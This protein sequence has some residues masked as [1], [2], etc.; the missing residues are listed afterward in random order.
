[1]EALAAVAAREALAAGGVP[2]Q[3][4][5]LPAG[6]WASWTTAAAAVTVPVEVSWIMPVHNGA[7]FLG[8]AL[9]S[10][11]AQTM[12]PAKV[13][14]ELSLVDD[15][16]TDATWSVVEGHVPRLLERGWV[17]TLGRNLS[18]TARGCGWG[19]NAAIKQARGRWVCFADADDVSHPDRLQV[20]LAAALRAE[21]HFG[22]D[23]DRT[24]VGANFVRTPPGSTVRYTA[25]LNRLTAAELHLHRF[26]EVTLIKPTWLLRHSRWASL[27]GLHEGG[28]GT[29]EDMLFFY[30]HLEHGGRLLKA[31]TEETGPLSFL[32]TGADAETSATA[33]P[34]LAALAERVP[35][36]PPWPPE[37][38]LVG[39]AHLH[40]DDN[41]EEDEARRADSPEERAVAREHGSRAG[42]ETAAVTTTRPSPRA[43]AT[44]AL[45][46]AVGGPPPLLTYRYHRASMTH[47]VHRDT[48]LVVRLRALERQVLGR[49]AHF[50]IWNAGRQ[51][52]RLYALL[53]PATQRKVTA[54][55][56]VAERK[57]AHGQYHRPGMTRAVPIVHFRAAVPPLL[58]CVK[59]D[60]TGGDFEA[61]LA[62]LGLRPGVDYVY[63]C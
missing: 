62:S 46:V 34:S 44:G 33:V 4:P 35:A 22:A 37:A 14:Q 15:A 45:D 50:T 28:R 55:C 5:P 36:W 40:D 59:M 60:L 31:G 48:L 17:V 38:T 27:G 7:A 63:F 57:L 18:G 42:A 29:P 26:V 32:H 24:L 10:L 58:L 16:S 39:G 25:W 54:F 51:G 12:A 3:Q 23:D 43:P 52:R 61:G 19:T 6:A 21:A 49:W 41:V 30:R 56:D 20:Q 8:E 2:L 9:A 11:L 47:T 1:V 53:A 13:T